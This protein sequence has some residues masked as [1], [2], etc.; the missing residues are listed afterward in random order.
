MIMISLKGERY[1]NFTFTFNFHSNFY[2]SENIKFQ[3]SLIFLSFQL[4]D[5]P[6]GIMPD[7]WPRQKKGITFFPQRKFPIWWQQLT[8]LSGLESHSCHRNCEFKFNENTDL[9]CFFWHHEICPKRFPIILAEVP[10]KVLIENCDQRCLDFILNPDNTDLI[11]FMDQYECLFK[12]NVLLQPTF[13]L[14]KLDRLANSS[15]Q[16]SVKCEMII[17]HFA[18]SCDLTSFVIPA[19]GSLRKIEY[20]KWI[21]QAH[22]RILK[23]LNYNQP[24]FR[25][26]VNSCDF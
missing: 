26:R 17:D 19:D 15:Y 5:T 16:L 1:V 4:D 9:A 11:E 3:H 22:S 21:Y 25:K 14:F 20:Q 8:I 7:S 6:I 2:T 12:Q 13:I 23:V 10:L 24:N 18:Q